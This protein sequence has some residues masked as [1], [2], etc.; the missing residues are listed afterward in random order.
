MAQTMDAAW[1]PR[2]TTDLG[3]E[4][5]VKTGKRERL[6]FLLEYAIIIISFAG[7]NGGA[8]ARETWVS[9]FCF[10]ITNIILC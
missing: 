2:V 7:Y 1:L 5:S 8:D 4:K 3:G 9:T 10:T 6:A